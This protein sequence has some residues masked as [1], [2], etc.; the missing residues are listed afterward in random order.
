MEVLTLFYNGSEPKGGKEEKWETHVLGRNEYKRRTPHASLAALKV[1][2][3]RWQWHARATMR[4]RN[5]AAAA[6]AAGRRPDTEKNV[7]LRGICCSLLLCS[8]VRQS[9]STCL[10]WPTHCSI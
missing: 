5:L 10:A 9:A 6:A 7:L 2:S 3:I 1:D 8:S 4:Q